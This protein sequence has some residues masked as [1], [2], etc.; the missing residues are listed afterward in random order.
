MKDHP[1]LFFFGFLVVFLNEVIVETF[2]INKAAANGNII[3]IF[4]DSGT[5]FF[6][7][8]IVDFEP[9]CL[10]CAF[11]AGILC[12]GLLNGAKLSVYSQRRGN[13][14]AVVLKDGGLYGAFTCGVDQCSCALFFLDGTARLIGFS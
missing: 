7:H 9:D 10:V 12:I 3:D 4:I 13:N 6:V 8:C 1:F 14:C 5:G 11:G 2:F